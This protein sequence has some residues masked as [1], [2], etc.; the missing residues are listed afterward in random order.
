MD[1]CHYTFIQTQRMYN[2]KSE[3]L[4]KLWTLV[5]NDWLMYVD[6]GGGLYMGGTGSMWEISVLSSQ[7]YC[8]TK[9]ALKK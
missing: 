5:D 8:K 3:T 9:T 2:T 4:G 7:F 1:I 6:G